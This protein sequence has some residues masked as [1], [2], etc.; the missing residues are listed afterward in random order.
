ME[1]RAPEFVV[2]HQQVFALGRLHHQALGLH[3]L[4]VLVEGRRPFDCRARQKG[5]VDAQRPQRLVGD[6]AE[7][8]IELLAVLATERD[9]I[10]ARRT[11]EAGDHAEIVGDDRQRANVADTFGNRAGR[12][13]VVDQD[14][15]PGLDQ[16]RRIFGDPPLFG[17]GDLLTVTEVAFELWARLDRGA[18]M[19]LAQQARLFEVVE[20][21]MHRHLADAEAQG[22]VFDGRRSGLHQHIHDRLSPV[23]R[24]HHLGPDHAQPWPRSP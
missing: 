22:Q 6:D 16:P 13:A 12:R 24:L 10:D 17:G 20:V 4:L 23:F 21:A 3:H 19:H 2:V 14:A 9:D 5:D 11:R 15:L 18:T 7:E 1:R 8:A